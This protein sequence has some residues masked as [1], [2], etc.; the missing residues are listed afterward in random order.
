MGSG[1]V[2]GLS[3]A[4]GGL[5]GL[6]AAGRVIQIDYMTGSSTVIFETGFSFWGAG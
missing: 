4:N 5:L 6:D 1:A 2:Y 3:F